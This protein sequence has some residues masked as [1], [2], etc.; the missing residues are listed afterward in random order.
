MDQDIY[1]LTQGQSPLLVSMPHVGSV[2]PED[3]RLQLVDRALYAED[4]DWHMDKLYA[5][6]QGMGA[7]TLV[8]RYSRYCV[9]LNRPPENVPMY[10]GV[11]NTELCPTHF[12]SGEALYPTGQEPSQQEI[13]RRVSHY[14]N[15][16][17]QALAQEIQRIKSIHGYAVVFDAHSIASQL[18]WLFDGQLPDLN[19][20]TV[21]GNS[22]APSLRDALSQVLASQNQFSYVVDGR[23]KGGYITRRYGQPAVGVHVV[24]LEKCW[25]S[26]MLETAPYAWQPEIAV[27]LQPLLRQILQ[28]MLDWKPTT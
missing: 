8:P 28:T 4:T 14:W 24:Q 19:L 10:P 25:R 18:P 27:K 5:F 1:T 9:D 20:G 21:T 2:I 12:F 3:I 22:C 15:P 26:Y 11:N 17:H 16:Y 13:E 6:A 7:T 23:F